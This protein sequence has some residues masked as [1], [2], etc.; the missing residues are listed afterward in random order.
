M[1]SVLK[2]Y[3]RL[4]GDQRTKLEEEVAKE[5][6]LAI[7]VNGRHFS[8]A[9]MSPQMKKEFVLGHLLS[10]RVIES[11]EDI[12]S[13]KIREDIAKVITK[14]PIKVFAAKKVIVSGCGGASG[15][16]DESK[17][18]KVDSKLKLDKEILFEGIKKILTSDLHKRTGGTHTCAILEVSKT[19]RS[20]ISEDIGRHNA[21]EK[22][23]GYALLKK[24]HFP[25]TFVVCT[26]RISSEMVLK[27]SVAQ[28]PIIASRGAV[29]SLAVEIANKT[30]LTV[31]GFVRGKRMNIYSNEQRIL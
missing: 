25:D 8:T 7:F 26:G 21:L 31:I 2:E 20:F 16:L 11:L 19:E 1:K 3:T 15:F 17:L 13:L 29:T 23:V 24:Y 22:I 30:G 6:A 14:N 5:V 9:M 27:C 18:P 4:D 10:E 28:I 12:E